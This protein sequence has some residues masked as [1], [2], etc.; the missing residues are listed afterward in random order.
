MQKLLEIIKTLEPFNLDLYSLE[1][2]KQSIQISLTN[3]YLEPT[4]RVDNLINDLEC[5]TSIDQAYTENGY[6]KIEFKD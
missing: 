4:D 6:L 5:L 2:T 1:Y 3:I